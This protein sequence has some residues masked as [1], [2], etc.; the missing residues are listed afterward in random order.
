MG[1]AKIACCDRCGKKR[2]VERINDKWLCLDC[3][4]VVIE[5]TAE[6]TK[7]SGAV[8]SQSAQ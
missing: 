4:E 3:Q 1:Y 8:E 6:A 5:R 2:Y 7:D